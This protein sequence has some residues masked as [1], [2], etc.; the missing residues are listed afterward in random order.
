MPGAN[1]KE[2]L[3]KIQEVNNKNKLKQQEQN[4]KSKESNN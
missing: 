1:I 3:A 4:T 2:D